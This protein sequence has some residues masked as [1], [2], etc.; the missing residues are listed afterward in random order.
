[1]PSIRDLAKASFSLSSLAT[2][3][4]ESVVFTSPATNE[5]LLGYF[6]GWTANFK[7]INH[8]CNKQESFSILAP[9]TAFTSTQNTVT[10]DWVKDQVQVY[11]QSD[12]VFEELFLQSE[13][14]CDL[15]VSSKLTIIFFLYIFTALLSMRKTSCLAW[16]V[17]T[18]RKSSSLTSPQMRHSLLNLLTPFPMGRIWP[19]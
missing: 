15:L 8:G 4:L 16:R 11:Q 5:Q 17:H 9:L 19:K 1:M 2:S 7:F 12:D 14:D 13:C 18:K 10:C 3:S 6:L